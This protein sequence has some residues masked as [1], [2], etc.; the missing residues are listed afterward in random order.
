MQDNPEKSEYDGFYQ[1]G[2]TQPEKSN[3]GP[4]SL[5]LM[6]VILLGGMMIVMEMMDFSILPE[7]KVTQPQDSASLEFSLSVNEPEVTARQESDTVSMYTV[8]QAEGGDTQGISLKAVY[9][10]NIDSVV[11]IT[12]R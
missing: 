4:M 12:S 5:V 8:P 11:S 2:P 9:A 1:S 7:A 10:D 3:A 6:L